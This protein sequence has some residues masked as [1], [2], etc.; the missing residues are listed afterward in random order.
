MEDIVTAPFDYAQLDKPTAPVRIRLNSTVVHATNIGGASASRG[1]EVIYLRGGKPVKVVAKN[2]ILACYNAVIPYLCPEMSETQKAALH[3]AV[4]APL[5]YTNVQIRNWQAIRAAG[6]RTSYCPGSFFSEVYLDFPVSIGSYHY[7]SAPEQPAV[8]HLVRVPTSPGLPLRDQFRA[9]RAELYATPFE[10]F[11]KNIY[12]Q[13]GRMFQPFGFDP[14]RDIQA[15]TVNRWAHGY[16]YYYLPLWDGD[17]PEEKRPNVIGR[18]RFGR[19]AI[20]NSDAGAM[21]E[22]QTAIDEA[23]RAVHELLANT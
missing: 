10:V 19:I 16:A 6:L 17:Q 5:T 14:H 3:C 2:C 8:L 15:I 21:P 22:T 11:E 18:Q 13:L 23:H 20:A 7:T 4:K 9:G 1:T 12:D